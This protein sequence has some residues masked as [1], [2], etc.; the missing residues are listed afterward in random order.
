MKHDKNEIAYKPERFHPLISIIIPVYNVVSYLREALDSA[1]HQTYENLEI[2]II[3][4]GSTDGAG[5]ICDEYSDD[6]RVIIIHQ[7]HQGV[8]AARNTGLDLARGEYIAF[9]DPDDAYHLSFIRSMLEAAF[10]ENVGIVICK[11]YQLQTSKQMDASEKRMILP[12]AKPGAYSRKDAIIS[13]FEGQLQIKIW[14]MLY[15][16]ELWEKQRFPTEY[17]VA[18]DVISLYS[19]FDLCNLV[20]VI[21]QPLYFYR[22]RS[23]S[24]SAIYTEKIIQDRIRACHF[25]EHFV[26]SHIPEIFSSEHLNECNRRTLC[27]LMNEYG[28]VKKSAFA[29][30]LENQII[31]LAEQ[32][33]IAN[34][35][36]K[37]KIGYYMI[38]FNPQLMKILY[39]IWSSFRSRI[40]KATG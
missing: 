35:D 36:L 20:Y 9:L 5:E 27:L 39:R 29:K 18:E 7:M 26:G 19:I 14:S 3:D 11:Y 33:G 23:E 22:K 31:D 8:S 2:I 1:I 16:R 13:L 17:D 12:S 25:I 15:K 32:T 30:E 21:E 38:R 10:R 4:D 37:V 24:L 34:C 28:H 6:S 40:R